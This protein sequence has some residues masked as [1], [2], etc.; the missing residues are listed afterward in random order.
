M[1]ALVILLALAVLVFI[2]WKLTRK[3]KPGS[4][5]TAGGGADGRDD[6]GNSDTMIV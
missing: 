6:G 5:G 2:G 4:G 1:D 3:P